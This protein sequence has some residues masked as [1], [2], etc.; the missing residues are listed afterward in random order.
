MHHTSS[1]FL[2]T[3]MPN[4]SH[5]MDWAERPWGINC[6]SSIDFVFIIY[7]W[8][9]FGVTQASLTGSR[10]CLIHPLMASF[11]CVIFACSSRGG[12]NCF[13]Q[14]WNF[15]HKSKQNEIMNT[16]H[17]SISL[18]SPRILSLLSPQSH[19]R[20]LWQG[21]GKNYHPHFLTQNWTHIVT[22][23]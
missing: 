3:L 1:P 14:S 19:H 13:D 22:K 16:P 18:S 7:N 2:I 11:F 10:S 21:F 4:L 20:D 9:G 12:S 6:S 15:L 23:I 8:N 5:L 17:L